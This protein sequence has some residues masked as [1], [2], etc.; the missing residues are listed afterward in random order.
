MT[1][2]SFAAYRCPIDFSEAKHMKVGM[3]LQW[4]SDSGVKLIR[5]I[6]P[7]QLKRARE[8]TSALDRSLSLMLAHSLNFG[9]LKL[10]HS[11]RG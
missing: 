7:T 3:Y 5:C 9:L 8:Q 11:R 10:A 6:Y 4:N 1:A 2:V